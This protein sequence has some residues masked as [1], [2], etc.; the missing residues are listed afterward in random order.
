MAARILRKPEGLE[1]RRNQRLG[2]SIFEIKKSRELEKADPL[3]ASQTLSVPL[4]LLTTLAQL[5]AHDI[6]H[7]LSTIYANAEF[8]GTRCP[9]QVGN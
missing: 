1:E 6:R 2:S 5:I 9:D 3:S 4:A 7:H 8:L